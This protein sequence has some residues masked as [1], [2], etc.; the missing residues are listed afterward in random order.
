MRRRVDQHGQL[1]YVALQL[2]QHPAVQSSPRG[3]LGLPYLAEPADLVGNFDGLG[4]GVVLQEQVVGQLLAGPQQRPLFDVALL[5]H[6]QRPGAVERERTRCAVG[7]VVVEVDSLADEE[8]SHV[9]G[10]LVVV[11]SVGLA[12]AGA[13][14]LV[15]VTFR[16]AQRVAEVVIKRRRVLVLLS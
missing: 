16:H 1:E 9:T 8:Q 5:K 14:G 6:G 3:Q 11:V 15:L 7:P 13:G 10:E 12:E 2:V 4:G